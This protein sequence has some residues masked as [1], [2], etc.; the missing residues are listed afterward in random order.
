MNSHMAAPGRAASLCCDFRVIYFRKIWNHMETYGKH[1]GDDELW[2]LKGKPMVFFVCDHD[3]PRDFS[4]Q[5]PESF[6][7]TASPDVIINEEI[8]SMRRVK[9]PSGND[10]YI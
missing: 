6:E 3:S 8:P 1:N 10:C 2:I 5:R 4:E 9:K 7:T